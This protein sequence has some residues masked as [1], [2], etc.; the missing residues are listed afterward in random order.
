MPMHPYL[1]TF[2]V[3]SVSLLACGESPSPRPADDDNPA[4]SSAPPG[5]RTDAPGIRFD[6][7]AVRR[8]DTIGVLVLDSIVAQRNIIDSTYVGTA[9]FRGRIELSGRTIPHFDSDLRDG[10]ICFEADSAAAARLPRWQGDLRRSWFCFSNSAD[11]ASALGPA[12][13]ERAASIAIDD[14]VI[15]RGLSDEVNSARLVEVRVP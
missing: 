3:A 13:T 12:G 1:R 15:H 2:I 5:E 9:G 4:T 6:P 7:S 10:S 11:A 8:G 14:F